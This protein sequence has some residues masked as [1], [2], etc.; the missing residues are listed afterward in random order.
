MP[1]RKR[2][3]LQRTR[4]IT[5][6]HT[7]GPLCPF[8]SRSYTYIYIYIRA[9]ARVCVCCHLRDANEPPLLRLAPICLARV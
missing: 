1:L 3:V 7:V 5:Y 4:Y 8:Y 9:R 2:V 6:E